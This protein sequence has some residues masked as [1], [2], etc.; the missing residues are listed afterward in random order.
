MKCRTGTLYTQRLGHFN[1][2]ATT[3]LCLLCHQPDSQIH[4]LWGCKNGLIQDMVTERQIIVSWLIIKPLGKGE[5]EG[6]VNF[7]RCWK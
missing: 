3:S 6:N 2:R 5:S 4:M 7:H 1:G